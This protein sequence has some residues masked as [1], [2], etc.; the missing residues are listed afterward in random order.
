M[1]DACHSLLILIERP[2]DGMD[3]V[4]HHDVWLI[5]KNLQ[6]VILTQE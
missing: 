2:N 4:W 3:V 1:G 6:Q 5:A